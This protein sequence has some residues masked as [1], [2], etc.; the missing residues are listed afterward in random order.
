MADRRPGS[1]AREIDPDG[2]I[3]GPPLS[4][5]FE[6]AADPVPVK[7]PEARIPA[8]P[9]QQVART[10]LSPREP[11][12]P[13]AY[14]RAKAAQHVADMRADDRAVKNPAILD[15][16]RLFAA[17]NAARK[18]KGAPSLGKSFGKERERGDD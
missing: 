5:A 11:A 13:A 18:A 12:P 17:Q 16:A 6:K 9:S 3:Q 10:N 15:K 14:D 4:P 2:S 1:Y 8:I 7:T